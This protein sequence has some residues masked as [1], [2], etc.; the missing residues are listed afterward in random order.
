MSGYKTHDGQ[1]SK[2]VALKAEGFSTT[3]LISVR[4]TAQRIPPAHPKPC[5]ICIEI[6]S[7]FRSSSSTRR[8]TTCHTPR[9][10]L[11]SDWT[12]Q[13]LSRRWRTQKGIYLLKRFAD[14]LMSLGLER[15]SP[16]DGLEHPPSKVGVW[17]GASPLRGGR[18]EPN[19]L[20]LECYSTVENEMFFC[21]VFGNWTI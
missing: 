11:S 9:Q 8:Q 6:P 14:G 21:E 7:E 4:K 15:L 17:T 5:R 18:E 1:T 20:A 12:P 19:R 2:H 3:P 16:R 13:P 10:T